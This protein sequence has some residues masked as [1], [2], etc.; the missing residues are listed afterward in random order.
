MPELQGQDLQRDHQHQ[1]GLRNVAQ[2][3]LPAAD[4]AARRRQP[5][6]ARHDDAQHVRQRLLQQP[7][8]PEG[9]PALGP[10]A[11][12]RQQ[13]RQHGQELR[14]QCR[15]LHRRLR[16]GHGQ[17]GEHRPQDGDAGADQARL[18]Q[19]ELLIWASPAPAGATNE[20][21]KVSMA[22]TSTRTYVQCVVG[23][24]VVRG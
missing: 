16:D 1:H 19:G 22:S 12:Q 13:H 17:H 2:G 24:S 15:R 20:L 14:V 3:Q 4:G 6:A 10:G 7:G 9:A 18:L 8:L 11:V 23:G 5:R 21:N